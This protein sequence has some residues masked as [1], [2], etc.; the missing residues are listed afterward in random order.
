[1]MPAS[2]RYSEH[3]SGQKDERGFP[4]GLAESILQNPDGRYYDNRNGSLVAV[5]RVY[6]SGRERDIVVAYLRQGDSVTLLTIHPLKTG[7]QQ[8]R[9]ES[10]RWARYDAETTL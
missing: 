5:K 7:Q 2:I 8:R 9:L 3:F 6:F 1:M 4:D 10:G